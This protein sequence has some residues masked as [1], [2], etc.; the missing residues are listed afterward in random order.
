MPHFVG[1][2]ADDDDDDAS[3]LIRRCRPPGSLMEIDDFE[4][5]VSSAIIPA[6]NKNVQSV[7]SYKE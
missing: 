5:M 1:E 4:G 6:L 7:K 3:L 2:R